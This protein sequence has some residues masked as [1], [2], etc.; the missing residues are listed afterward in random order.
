MLLEINKLTHQM[1][2]E[3]V[4]LDSWEPMFAEANQAVSSPHGRITLHIFWELHYDFLP[5]FCYNSTTDRYNM[6][7]LSVCVGRRGSIEKGCGQ[8]ERDGKVEVE[9]QGRR[10][11]EGR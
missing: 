1:L 9:P 4:S 11:R 5:N 2:A 6:Y 7:T 3:H 10:E 8:K